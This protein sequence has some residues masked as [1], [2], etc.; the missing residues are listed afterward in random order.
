[1]EL[2][3]VASVG[4]VVDS[5]A[6][7]QSS[8]YAERDVVMVPLT[9]RFGQEAYLDWT[10][11]QPDEFYRR[12]AASEELPK[13]S[14]P[15]VS[16]FLDAYNALSA[17][18]DS[19]ISLHL[20]ARLSGTVQSAEIAAGQLDFPVTVIDSKLASLGIAL[21]LER[22]LDGRAAGATHD[23]LVSLCEKV[24]G[25]VRTLFYVDTLRYLHMG[26]R[27]GRA[28]ALAGSLL[29]IR[30]ILELGRDGVVEP[31]RKVKGSEKVYRE[32]V[33]AVRRTADGRPVKIAFV[34][35]SNTDAVDRLREMLVAEG[36]TLDERFTSY[37]GCVIGT[38]LGP[39]AFG[40]IFYVDQG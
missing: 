12:L 37:V 13:T 7:L 29:K 20:S 26:G 3:P 35:A 34:H 19:I 9:V 21:V 11:L 32:L 18:C 17:R 10:D 4:I 15:S 38:Y 6:D 1:M 24:A 14:Q 39:G 36:V 16:Q 8:Y 28:S 22:L 30:P 25:S 2:R 23:E 5:T 40:A 27:I 33:E 31:Y